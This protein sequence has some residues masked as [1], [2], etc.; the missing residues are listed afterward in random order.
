MPL[1]I[2]VQQEVARKTLTPLF[3]NNW[4]SHLLGVG[5]ILCRQNRK[6]ES[7][8]TWLKE[9]EGKSP[10]KQNKGRSE[11][12]SED[13]RQNQQDSWLAQFTQGRPR[14][15]RK[16]I[17]RGA[18][19]ARGLSLSSAQALFL[20]LFSSHLLGRHALMPGGCILLYFLNK[21]DLSENYNMDCPRAVTC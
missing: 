2:P 4:A 13:L 6:K 19:G 18:K 20:S 5:G 14:G 15:R 8:M 12:Q 7:R 11:H 9:K 3:P 21:T 17:K 16:H 1:T 10:R